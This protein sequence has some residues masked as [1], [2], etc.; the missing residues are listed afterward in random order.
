MKKYI[1]HYPIHKQ[2]QRPHPVFAV[3][4][5]QWEHNLW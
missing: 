2:N 5:F 4:K 3:K 1:C